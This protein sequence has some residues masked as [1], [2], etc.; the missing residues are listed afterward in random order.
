M[1]MMDATTALCLCGE[2]WDLSLGAAGVFGAGGPL[3][4]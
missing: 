2:C 1:F 3:A 4:S